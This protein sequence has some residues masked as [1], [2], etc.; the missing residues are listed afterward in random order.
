MGREDILMDAGSLR[1]KFGYSDFK[2]VWVEDSV[3]CLGQKDH[4]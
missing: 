4:I 1:Q 2:V 3:I